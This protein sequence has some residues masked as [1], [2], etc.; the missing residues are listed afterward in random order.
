MITV[1]VIPNLLEEL[2]AKAANKLNREIFFDKGHYN[3]VVRNLTMKVDSPA[4]PKRYPLVWLVMD[5]KETLNP[6]LGIYAD[7]DVHLIFAMDTDINYT[8]DQR[9]TNNFIPVLYPIFQELLNQIED[10]SFFNNSLNSLMKCEKWDRPYWGGQDSQG[11]GQANIFND[12]IDAIQVKSLRL[13]V[14]K[15]FCNTFSI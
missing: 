2:V 5:M 14:K 15:Q 7:I 3:E 12:F 11:N 9:V 6:R 4:K 1:Q 8:L 10:C 13:S